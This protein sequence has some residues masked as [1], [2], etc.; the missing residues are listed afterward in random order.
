MEKLVLRIRKK[1]VS[2]PDI[3]WL[4]MNMP[5]GN[6]TPLVSVLSLLETDVDNKYI[7]KTLP[8]VRKLYLMSVNGEKL[9]D[10]TAL[11][12]TKK[13]CHSCDNTTK[14]AVYNQTTEFWACTCLHCSN[15]CVIPAPVIDKQT[16]EEDEE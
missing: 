11:K 12:V 2:D 5:E 6:D 15:G 8:V 7:I 16:K 3:N 9:L 10:K 4:D 14:M 13:Y 1:F